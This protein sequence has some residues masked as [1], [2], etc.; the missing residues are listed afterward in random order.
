MNS[1]PQAEEPVLTRRQRLRAFHD[2][3]A[4]LLIVPIGVIGATA[5]LIAAVAGVDASSAANKAEANSTA[6]AALVQCLND[7]ASLNSAS[8]A[9]VRDATVLR[10]D[11]TKA[12][13]KALNEE[14]VAFLQL[15]LDLKA[16]TVTSTEAF[17]DLIDTLRDRA[18]KAKAL[19]TAQENLD[20]VR[21]Q[22]PTVPSPAVF[23]DVE[24]DDEGKLVDRTP[25]P[26]PTE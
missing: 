7:Y 9:L 16:G 25:S 21:R 12:R 20:E 6:N 22:N 5:L 19:E 11:A 1:E 23:C 18:A 8:N 3:V 14:G 2:R 13:D 26:S 10:D 15:V 4:P 17:N 24:L